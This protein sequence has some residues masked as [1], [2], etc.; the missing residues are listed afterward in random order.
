MIATYPF[1]PPSCPKRNEELSSQWHDAPNQSPDYS[2]EN[3]PDPNGC[4]NRE[5]GSKLIKVRLISVKHMLEKG[6]EFLQNHLWNQ[7]MRSQSPGSSFSSQQFAR[8]FRLWVK[9]GPSPPQ[10][11]FS[12]GCKAYC[13]F[14]S[15]LA[16]SIWY[17]ESRVFLCPLNYINL[18][19]SA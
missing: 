16:A 17:L 6:W 19:P 14:K 4:S 12:L 3:Q 8:L 18:P 7:D 10:M 11:F 1:Y 15:K 2:G 5:G 13:T 9:L